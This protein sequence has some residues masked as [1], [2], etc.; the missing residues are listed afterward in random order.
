MLTLGT[1]FDGAVPNSRFVYSQL[2]QA[3]SHNNG[4]KC[5]E[6]RFHKSSL[7]AKKIHEQSLRGS[8]GLESFKG[9]GQVFAIKH[10]EARKTRRRPK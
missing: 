1:T 2:S 7:P 3:S 8:A 9:T 10:A 4:D 6:E 5:T